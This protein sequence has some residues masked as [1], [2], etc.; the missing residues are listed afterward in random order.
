MSQDGPLTYLA[1][2]T[3]TFDSAGTA[4]GDLAHDGTLRRGVRAVLTDHAIFH[5]NRIGLPYETQSIFAHAARAVILG[6]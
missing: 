1:D 6:D 2:W 5:W 3:A 4:L